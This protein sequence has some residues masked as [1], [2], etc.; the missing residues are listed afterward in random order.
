[1]IT[2]TN[3]INAPL[4]ASYIEESISKID[5]TDNYAF[6]I[7]LSYRENHTI[8]Y[9]DKINSI[10]FERNFLRIE[11]NNGSCNYYDYDEIN[12]YHVINSNDLAD[13]WGE[14]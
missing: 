10:N 14:V 11:H 8:Y 12:E 4:I 5:N 3:N 6:A 1:L 2:V 9:L 7:Q 13:L